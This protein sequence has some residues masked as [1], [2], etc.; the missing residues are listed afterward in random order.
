MSKA[1]AGVYAPAKRFDWFLEF[2]LSNADAAPEVLREVHNESAVVGLGAACWDRINPEWRPAELAPF[3]SVVGPKHDAPATQRDL[4]I[5]IA[6][7]AFDDLFDR[8]RAVADRIAASGGRLADQTL[9]FDY[10]D[11]HDLI[12]FE[13]GTA[14]PKGDARFDAAQVP[15]G[16]PGAG[17]SYVFTQ[18]W[19]HDLNA[20]NALETAAQEQVVGRTKLD[21]IELEGDA[22]PPSSHV[23]RTDLKIDGVAQKIFRRSMP[24]GDMLDHGLYFF[25]FACS[26]QRIQVQLDSMYDVAGSGVYDHLLDY[27][28]AVS[29]SY[30]FVPAR[31]DLDQMIR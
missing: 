8:S 3:E 2:D 20:F 9:G 19:V 24:Y 10:H 21:S 22:M 29:G 13:D 26:L 12:G 11:S 31:A 7:D 17:G 14:N 25:A 6:G 5:W 30:W 16:E 23:S 15:N 1:Q 28:R 4:F 27:S 18:K